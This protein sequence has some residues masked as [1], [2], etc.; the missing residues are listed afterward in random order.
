MI[1][2]K[3]GN[4]W[5][6]VYGKSKSGFPL[7]VL[8]G[9]PGFLSMPETVL[10]LANKRPVHF[11]DQLGCSLSDKAININTYTP[12]FYVE[13]LN[14]VIKELNLKDFVLM[15]FSWGTMLAVLYY[16][17]HKPKGLRALILCAPY[18]S[19]PIWDKD[20][21][22]NIENMPSKI[23]DAILEGEEK[24]DFGKS[25]QDAVLEYYKKHLCRLEPW[26]DFVSSAFYK[27]N[28]DIYKHLWGE[29]EFTI[30]GLLKDYD[31]IPDLKKINIP[32]LFTC[33][34]YD[35][36]D[37]KTVALFN[38]AVPNSVMTVIPDA[39][40]LHQIEKPNLFLDTV[41]SFLNKIE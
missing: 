8:H 32:T 25:Y 6:N 19:T 37:P 14:T 15:G 11:Y 16:L 31:L 29:S 17:K 35:E 9:G 34:E 13:E 28:K 40:H 21:R 4:L 7:L 27:L 3:Y 41:R 20:Q 23:R 22:H 10:E 2:T 5:H 36:A 33:G 24:L 18:L 30:S 12:E 26:P 1:P 39:S 38:K